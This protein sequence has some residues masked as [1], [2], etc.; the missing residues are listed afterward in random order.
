MRVN[1]R[2]QLSTYRMRSRD[3]QVAGEFLEHVKSLPL[4]YE[5]GQYFRLDC[6]Y[7][8]RNTLFL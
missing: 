3:L 8:T 7:Y 1:G 5:K 4:E 2:V 6:Y